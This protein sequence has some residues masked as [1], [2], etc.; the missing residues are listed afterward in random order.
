VLGVEAT[1]LEEVVIEGEEDLSEETQAAPKPVAI[2]KS[3]VGGISP[4]IGGQ[5]PIQ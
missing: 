2:V 4:R 3:L 1:T 5:V